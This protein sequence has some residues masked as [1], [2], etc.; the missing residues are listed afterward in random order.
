VIA[1]AKR[2]DEK[3]P[4]TRQ[5]PRNTDTDSTAAFRKLFQGW[6]KCCPVSYLQNTILQDIK[7]LYVFVMHVAP[8]RLFVIPTN[9]RLTTSIRAYFLR[10]KYG[11]VALAVNETRRMTVNEIMFSLSLK[12]RFGCLSSKALKR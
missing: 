9:I 2:V 4:A 7:Y 3:W 8:Y 12:V 10:E 5:E 11:S 6:A 1:L